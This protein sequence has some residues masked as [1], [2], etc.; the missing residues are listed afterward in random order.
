MTRIPLHE[1]LVIGGNLNGNV[2]KDISHFE[3]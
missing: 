2:G 3:V 1:E